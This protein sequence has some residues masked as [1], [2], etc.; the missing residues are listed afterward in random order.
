M[1]PR[2]I[3][4]ADGAGENRRASDLLQVRMTVAGRFPRARAVVRGVLAGITED[5]VGRWSPVEVTVSRRRDGRAVMTHHFVEAL[6]AAED[7][8]AIERDLD[9][10]TPEE[11]CE[12]YTI[13]PADL[14]DQ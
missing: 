2:G 4:E 14:D 13:D 8:T 11:F 9:S 12:A 5:I 1:T 10:M 6:H 3:D 7:M